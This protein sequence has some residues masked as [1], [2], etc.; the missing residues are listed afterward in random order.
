[1]RQTCIFSSVIV[2]W[3]GSV[4]V[5][6][7]RGPAR[8]GIVRRKTL[9]GPVATCYLP[10][11]LD[12]L[13]NALLRI[14]RSP[15]IHQHP[16]HPHHPP[17]GSKTKAP[18]KS[19]WWPP[20]DGAARRRAARKICWSYLEGPP[21]SFAFLAQTNG[22]QHGIVNICSNTRMKKAISG[23]ILYRF[24]YSML[25]R[26]VSRAT[27]TVPFFL[28]FLSILVLVMMMVVGNAPTLKIAKRIVH[29]IIILVVRAFRDFH[30]RID[31]GGGGGGGDWFRTSGRRL[32]IM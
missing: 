28:H 32:V 16:Y 7:F 25:D 8:T 24:V 14:K 20:N 10:D 6:F 3:A 5:K 30:R 17:R 18:Q 4:L 13:Q 31:C 21:N 9:A 2:S 22:N 27:D 11:L 23:S 26:T 29:M 15:S 12:A 1:M 19:R